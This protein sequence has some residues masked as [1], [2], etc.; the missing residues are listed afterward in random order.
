MKIN[1]VSDLHLD[2]SKYL[3]LPGGDV[4]IIAGDACE[5]KSWHREFHETKL[6]DRT[7]GGFPCADF[8][9]FQCAKYRKVFYVMGNHEHYHGKFWKTYAQIKNMLPPNA[10][11]LEKSGFSLS[12]F[13]A[14]PSSFPATNRL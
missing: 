10:S 3:E 2:I 7:P 14:M 1:L 8:F 11:I 5:A 6:I 13:L 9:K 4:L 12:T